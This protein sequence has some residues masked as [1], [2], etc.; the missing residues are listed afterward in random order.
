MVEC[1]FAVNTLKQKWN[2]YMSW[3]ACIFVEVILLHIGLCYDSE[4]QGSEL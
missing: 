2:K 3:T 4:V 1:R